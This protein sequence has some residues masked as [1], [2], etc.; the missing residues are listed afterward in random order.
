VPSL[1]SFQAKDI[2]LELGELL[3]AF[4]GLLFLSFGCHLAPRAQHA[5]W[6]HASQ[7]LWCALFLF[8]RYVD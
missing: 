7:G 2:V 3:R 1:I 4:W 5:A 8:M 6:C